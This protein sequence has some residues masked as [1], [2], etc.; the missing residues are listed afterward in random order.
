MSNLTEKELDRILEERFGY[1]MPGKEVELS[2]EFVQEREDILQDKEKAVAETV[3][4][5]DQKL[6]ASARAFCSKIGE[7]KL[8]SVVTSNQ[9]SI[10]VE[11]VTFTC[12][13]LSLPEWVYRGKVLTKA[14]NLRKDGSSGRVTQSNIVNAK[15]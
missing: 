5:Y 11:K 3:A 4:L 2:K 8:G 12:P 10:V 1:L 13:T 15:L 9:Y 6:A 7:D 14:G